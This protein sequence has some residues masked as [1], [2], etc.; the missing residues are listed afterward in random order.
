MDVRD[1]LGRD[2][3]IVDGHGLEVSDT[4][5]ERALNQEGV[6]DTLEAYG[7]LRLADALE[8]VAPQEYRHIIHGFHH[9]FLVFLAE[10]A[11]RGT[12]DFATEFELRKEGLQHL[13]LADHGIGGQALLRNVLG[14]HVLV[15][16]AVLGDVEILVIEEVAKLKQLL[17]AKLGRSEVRNALDGEEAL[18]LAAHHFYVCATPLAYGT[19]VSRVIQVFVELGDER[20]D[21][22]PGLDDGVALAFN[23]GVHHLG[24]QVQA[25]AEHL[26]IGVA[27]QLDLAVDAIEELAVVD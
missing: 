23:E 1:A 11:E 4:A 5:A 3:D 15:K 20:L 24:S 26:V 18:Q 14:L 8:L 21:V 6:A 16:L 2:G 17:F 12:V 10:G 27:H 22:V 9:G 13:E 7:N 25:L 19:D